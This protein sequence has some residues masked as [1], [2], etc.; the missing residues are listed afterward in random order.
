MN[1]QALNSCAQ[2]KGQGGAPERGHKHRLSREAQVHRSAALSVFALCAARYHLC[3]IN[4]NF[5]ADDRIGVPA[6]VVWA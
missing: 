3:E 1:F 5:M 2:P 4:V 6:R